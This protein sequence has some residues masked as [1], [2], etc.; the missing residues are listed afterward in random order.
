MI[1]N[2]SPKARFMGSKANVEAHRS[3]MQ[4]DDL[5]HS[6]DFALLEYQRRVAM[7]TNEQLAAT[8]HFRILGALEFIQTMKDLAES[9]P[10]PTKIIPPSLNHRA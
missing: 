9:T 8:G 6:I 3:L 10:E 4:R 1:T 5:Q 2:P 7:I